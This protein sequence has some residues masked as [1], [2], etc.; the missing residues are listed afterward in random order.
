M[1][2]LGVLVNAP[3]AGGLGIVHLGGGLVRTAMP[4]R[5]VVRERPVVWRAPGRSWKIRL[6]RMIR[7]PIEPLFFH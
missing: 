4:V 6:A 7:Y 3:R 2:L 1:L 5:A